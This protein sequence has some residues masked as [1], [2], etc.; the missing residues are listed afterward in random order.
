M[1]AFFRKLKWLTERRNK[2][3]ELREE[4]QFHL[5]EEAEQQQ[6]E[7]L[8]REQARWAARRELGNLTLLQENTRDVWG[9]TV[10]EQLGQ[11][12]RYAFRTMAANRLFTFLA[13]SSLALG[14][15]ANTAIY[16]FMDSILLRSLPVSDPGSLVVLNWHAKA[17]AGGRDFV[18]HGM[19]GSTWG[20]PQSGETSGMFPFPAF[21]LFQKY[22]SV[23]STVF[24]HYSSWQIK[25]LNL[26][27]K[28]QA[29]IAAG[30]YVS[31]GYFGGLAV[32]PVAGRLIIPDDDRAGARPVA[33]VSYAYS[34]RRFGGA[35]NAAGQPILID[36][37]PFTVVGVTPPEFFGVDPAAAPDVYLPMHTNELMGAGHQFGFRPENYLARNYYWIQVMGRLR[38]GVSLAQAQAELAPAFQQWVAGTADN[39]RERAN[40]PA[41]VIVPGAGGLESLRRRYSQPLYVLMTLVALILALACANVANLLLARAAA[42]RREMALRLSVGAGRFRIVRQLLTESVLLA[43]MGGVLGVLFAIWGIR[44]LTLLLANGRANFTLRAELNWHVLG[45]AAA[46]SLL[47]GVLFGLAPAMQSTRVDVISALKE[48]RAGQPG[49]RH[50][51][52]G[53]SIS[54]A[55][56]VCQIA[57]SLLMLVA[58]GLFVRTLSNL[59]SIELGFN[60]EN[61][62]LFQLDAR[63]AGHK[64]PEIA[65]F[66]G[67]LRQRFSE[68]PG[69]RSASLSED[70]LIEAGTG[71]PIGVSGAPSSPDNRILNVGPAFFGTMQIPILAGRD[72]DESDRPASPAVAVINEVFAK[73]NFGNRN[74]LGQ[75]LIMRKG[76]KG[77]PLARDMEIVG[78]SRNARYGGLKEAIP[79]LVYMPYNQGYPQ[80]DQMV[81]ALRT[82]G[83]P[84]RYVNS[85]RETVRQADA[86][87][88]VSEIRTQAADI[89]QTIN[90]EITFARLCTGFAILALA[91]ACVGLYGT[92][93][94]NVARRTGEIGIRMALGAQRGGVVRMVLRD[95]LALAAVGLA[96]GLPTALGTSKFVASF[97][98]GM[99]SNDPLAL[100]LAVV[101][102]LGAAILAGYLPARKASRID[103]MSALRHE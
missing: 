45:A 1:N 99:K 72:F 10:L 81:Y 82:S 18:M 25:R 51:F 66:Y 103:P 56:M 84:L 41:L 34:Q 59:Q 74:P 15:G 100:T 97:L 88:P 12:L 30:E 33:V 11:D 55:L 96:I 5:A 85:A 32:P 46:L 68:I 16:S 89:D 70:S 7:G 40:L 17:N 75:H 57:I 22:E 65:A 80:P 4:L 63:K 23:F 24:A 94:Y 47:T 3:A 9:W 86:R 95:V 49:A 64:D 27:I 43:S 93:S 67:D 92:V 13:V 62:L 77:E 87:V 50:S 29:G 37:L 58:A 42:R 52:R 54:H 53:V 71:L 48:T 31:G 44:F 79:P 35:A 60:R 69:V 90:Q 91:I 73:A 8:A 20:D 83:D 102:L 98:Y 78:V 14:I 76:G 28:G 26:T 2:E 21:E 61:V 19:S 101:T 6:A 38:P 39:E 36:N